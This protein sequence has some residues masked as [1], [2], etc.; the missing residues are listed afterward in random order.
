[1]H[2]YWFKIVRRPVW[3]SR[4]LLAILLLSL[5]A[6]LPAD[7]KSAEKNNQAASKSQTMEFRVC[8]EQG[9]PLPGAK[10]FANVAFRNQ[11]NKADIVNSHHVADSAGKITLQF[12][13]QTESMRLWVTRASYVSQFVSFGEGD[14]E[15][16]KPFPKQFEFQLA[17]GSKISGIVVDE[18]DQP[19]PDVNVRVGLTVG[20]PDYSA[21]PQPIIN[22]ETKAVTDKA[23]KW[24]INIAPAKQPGKDVQFR[25]MFTHDDYISD[26]EPGQLQFQQNLT[27]SMLRDGTARIVLRRGR[28]VQGT[29]INTAG[30]PVTKG[31]VV[32]ND[33]PYFSRS[34][35]ETK[36][37]KS[38]H[39][40]TITLPPGK[41]PV[42]VV[43]PGYMPVR[44]IVNV[45]Q[46]LNEL[47]FA[48]KPGKRLTLKIVDSTGKPV[49]RA[50][51]SLQGWRGA[52]SL[53]NVRHSNVLNSGIPNRADENGIF[54]WDW[55][56]ADP[57]TYHI[58]GKSGA[59]SITLVATE[60]PHLIQLD[61]PL[62]VSGTVTDARTGKPISKFRA[63]PVVEFRPDFL[64]TSF[65]NT[66]TGKDGKYEITLDTSIDDRRHLIRIEAD[67]YRSMLSDSSFG[68]VEGPV[69]QN[70][71]LEPAPARK[72]KVVDSDGKPVANASIRI[73]TPSIVPIISNNVS[74]PQGMPSNTLAG[75]QFEIA[76]TS[77]PTRIR[78]THES[79]YAEVLRQP[80]EE[81]GTLVLQPWASIS[82]RLMQSDKPVGG[83]TIQF[84]P[85]QERPLGSA[86]LQDSYTALT[87]E[88]GRFELKQLPPIAGSVRAILGPWV[89]SPLTSSRSIPL[90]LQPGDHKTIELGDQG[91]IITGTVVETGRDQAP[92]NKKWSINYLIRRDAGLDWPADAPELSFD[93]TQPLHLAALEDPNFFTWQSTRP[94]H[95][96]KLTPDGQLKINGVPP[97][98]YDLVLKLYEPPAGCLVNPIGQ[99]IIPI[100]VTEQDL[101]SGTLTLGQLTVPCKLG[102]QTG[103]NLYAFEF[104]DPTGQAHSLYE[105]KGRYVLLQAWASWC[106]PCLKS[107][108]EIQ[109]LTEK[110]SEQKLTVIGLNL[111]QDPLEAQN[112][113]KRKGWNWTQHYMEVETDRARKLTVSSVPVYF[114]VG[115]N[116]VVTSVSKDWNEMQQTIDGLLK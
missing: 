104:T 10:L 26:T 55:A 79:G 25:L 38:G 40:K 59:K 96:V 23:G 84:K 50:I 60:K 11:L 13:S 112:L 65:Q 52:K 108:P 18:S 64:T 61:R 103:S 3:L 22:I 95:F 8:D 93:P 20:K 42:T 32:W 16:K 51:V 73:G 15:K 99:K 89:D 41:H 115:P 83:E 81:I 116:G 114:L 77:E 74:D 76:A 78:A 85:I 82:G 105:L 37:D 6:S 1:M 43:A 14:S 57:V 36:L 109:A 28:S 9:K 2:Y 90:D 35:N 27:T 72:G 44:Q 7:K 4:I 56:P 88:N 107:M 45:D 87:D 69:T 39:F 33:S 102:P 30:D 54:T 12:P 70:F 5:S 48:L 53:Y 100:E 66:V 92:L 97:G 113:V 106:A 24:S 80:D 21:N 75:G 101:K 58:R 94:Y 71:S 63:I 19:I 111:D 91:I 31:I 49:P 62:T 47:T 67:G 98:K 110:Y 34:V 68:L 86:R 29:V 17:H 46:S